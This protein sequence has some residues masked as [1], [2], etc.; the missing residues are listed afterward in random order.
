MGQDPAPILGFAY[1][2]VLAAWRTGRGTHRSLLFVL[3]RAVFGEDTRFADLWR[4]QRTVWWRQF[5]STLTLR[6]LSPWRAFTQPVYQL[7]GQR[8]R[9]GVRRRSQLLGG[10]WNADSF[11][12]D[13]HGG[14]HCSVYAGVGGLI[15][16]RSPTFPITASREAPG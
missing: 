2:D 13:R 5:A 1:G 4:A 3:S 16:G 6:R 7:E 9:A 12:G 10:R 8:W 15:A 14:R 11:G